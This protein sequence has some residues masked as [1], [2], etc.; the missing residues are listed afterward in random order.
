[1]QLS[2]T[3]TTDSANTTPFAP[4]APAPP[5]GLPLGG[6]A[7]SGGV[8]VGGLDASMGDEQLVQ[9][10]RQLNLDQDT[11]DKVRTACEEGQGWGGGAQVG[12]GRGG[13][14]VHPRLVLRK[15]EG[16]VGGWGWR[17][18]GERRV[19]GEEEWAQREGGWEQ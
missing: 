13:F 6:G 1:M 3:N 4:I 12:G 16:R 14:G 17:D 2:A 15:A 5:G 9:W 11:I 7:L 10:L 19:W 8:G 18:T